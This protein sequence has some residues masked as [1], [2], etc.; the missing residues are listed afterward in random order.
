MP[1]LT[2]SWDLG[3]KNVHQFDGSV[4][5]NKNYFDAW[6]NSVVVAAKTSPVVLKKH[7]ASMMKES[8]FRFLWSTVAKIW[9]DVF[10]KDRA[11][12]KNGM[13]KKPTLNDIY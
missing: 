4:S 8:R 11:L 3:P 6:V 5:S 13:M 7:R 10:E 1:E 12:L 9:N 2:K